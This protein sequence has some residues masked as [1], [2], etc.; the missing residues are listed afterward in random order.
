MKTTLLL[1]TLSLTLF[2]GKAQTS[3]QQEG[4]R[5]PQKE[6]TVRIMSYNIR[7]GWGM[8]NKIDFERIGKLIN[9][10]QPE[11]IGLQE[12]DSVV[13]RSGNIDI[14]Q[15]LSEQTGMHATFGYSILH[16]GGKYGNGVLSREKP[17]AVHKIS[18][19]GASEARSALVVELS[20]YVVINTHLSLKEEERVESAKIIS[21]WAKRYDKPVFLLG[22]LNATPESEP[23]K[24]LEKEW[25]ILSNTKQFT[26]PAPNPNKT[27]D[28]VLG[29]VANGQT[30]GKHYAHVIDEK[31]A[32]DHRPLFVDIRLKTDPSKVMRTIPYLQN[33]GKDEMTVMWL[34]NVPTRSWVEYGTDPNNMTV[35]RTM[36]EG[37]MVANNKIHRIHLKNLKPGTKYYYRVGSQ[38]ITRYSSYYKEFGDTVRSEIKSFTTWSDQQRDFRVLV[39][40]DIHSNMR[41]FEKLHDY[42][43]DKPYDLVIFNGDCFDDVEVESNIMN[44]LLTYMPSIKSDEVPSIFIRGNHE[45]RGE[46]SLFLWDYLGR[47]GGRSYSAFSLGDTRFVLL[48]CGEDKPDDH[49]E[50]SNMN[51]FTQHRIDQ[52]EFLK[53]E[54]KSNAYRKAKKR[55]LIHHIPIYGVRPGSYTPCA[56]LWIPVLDKAKE[57]FN[58]SL[59]GHT[60]RFR[61][62]EKNEFNNPFPV[63]VG[64]GNREPG[65]TVMVLEKKGDKL[66]LQVI[67]TEGETLLEKQL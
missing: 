29:Y 31:V 46:Y 11:V 4:S 40:N 22:D 36:L 15:L 55:I 23:I 60:H 45:T 62:I 51:D 12:V 2:S 6:R 13:N 66:T 48:D 49:I 39:Y 9:D 37:V 53:V 34:T 8:D 56:D 57:K 28:Y 33:P 38:E 14:L 27:I 26:I 42:V 17:L 47:M 61:V 5:F 10:V 18:L 64:G 20:K 67:N 59:N 43:D 63:I 65:G 35:A 58:I 16:D 30:Y 54:L 1:L 25:Q 3:T 21:E 41:M 52:A 44:R 7:H 19:P 24:I 32:S 50:Y